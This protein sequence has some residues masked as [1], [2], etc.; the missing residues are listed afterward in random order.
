ME[1]SFLLVIVKRLI[2]TVRKDLK[3]ILMSA[4]I[5]A[6]MVA[7]YFGC[8][9]KIY[10]IE[11]RSFPVKEVYVEDIVRSINYSFDNTKTQSKA[12]SNPMEPPT[13]LSNG[14]EEVTDTTSLYDSTSEINFD[15]LVAATEYVVKDIGS[16]GILVFLPGLA[17]ILQLQKMLK[18]SLSVLSNVTILALH[19]SLSPQEQQRVF[20]NVKGIKIVLSTNIAETSVTIDG[21]L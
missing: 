15:L 5:N 17:E 19:S 10:H 9:D 8:P 18:H 21:K 16:G 20:E 12:P 11:G 3:L 6:E 4:S 2:A 7:S 14:A 1:I 13:E